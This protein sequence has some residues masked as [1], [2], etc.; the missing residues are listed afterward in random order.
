M[1]TSFEKFMASSAVQEVELGEHKIEL[2]LID[3]F[4][5]LKSS[6]ILSK[7]IVMETYKELKAKSLQLDSEIK[8][9][10]AET[11]DLSNVKDNLSAKYKE[12]GMN[13]ESSKEFADFRKAFENQKQILDIATKIKNL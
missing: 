2:A 13:F 11:I 12:L 9:Y 10:V 5:K 1:K 7:D 3:D 8:K 4:K 6:A